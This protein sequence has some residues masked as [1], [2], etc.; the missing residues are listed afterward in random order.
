MDITPARFQCEWW[1]VPQIATRADAESFGAA[2]KCDHNSKRQS[3]S[4]VSAPVMGAAGLA[5]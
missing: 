3:P 1:Y 2:W 5:P 4:T